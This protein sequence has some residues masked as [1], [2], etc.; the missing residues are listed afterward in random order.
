MNINDR[1][2]ARRREL[3]L[4]LE[5]LGDAVGVSKSTVRKWET[6]YIENMRQDKISKLSKALQC[7]P[8]YLMGW[9]NEPNTPTPLTRELVEAVINDALGGKPITQEMLD[10]MLPVIKAVAKGFNDSKK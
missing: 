3:G 4:T 8:A 7:S 2:A 9:N 10:A 6:G 1:I 5:E